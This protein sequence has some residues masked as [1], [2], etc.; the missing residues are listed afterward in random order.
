MIVEGALEHGSPIDEMAVASELGVSRGP[1]RE[2]LKVLRAEGLVE[3]RPRRG[4]SVV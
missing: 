2:A 4:A 3:V 1:V